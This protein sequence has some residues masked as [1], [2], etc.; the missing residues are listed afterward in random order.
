MS[1]AIPLLALA[2]NGAIL[3]WLAHALRKLYP[4]MRAAL[5]AFAISVAVHSATLLFLDAENR[6]VALLFWGVPHMLLLPILIYS[7]RRA[8][9]G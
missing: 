1:F 2:Y 7:A 6:L 4:P 3:F 8:N 9:Q 5:T